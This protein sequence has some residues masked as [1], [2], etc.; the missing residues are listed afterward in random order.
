MYK[1]FVPQATVQ[2]SVLLLKFFRPVT[3]VII[4]G[5]SES[6]PPMDFLSQRKVCLS[7]FY[8][9]LNTTKYSL[10]YYIVEQYYIKFQVFSPSVFMILIKKFRGKH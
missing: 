1:A 10:P 5:L 9:P 6:Y 3:S 8:Q 2:L 7:P 4:K